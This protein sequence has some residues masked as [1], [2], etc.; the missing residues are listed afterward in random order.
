LA[1]VVERIKQDRGAYTR[2]RKGIRQHSKLRADGGQI[3]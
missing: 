2:L 3:A 1:N